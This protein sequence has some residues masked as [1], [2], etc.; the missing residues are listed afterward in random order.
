M[1]I[2]LNSF[3][4]F[5]FLLQFSRD[6]GKVVDEFRLRVVYIPA[7]PPSPVPEGDEEGTTSPGTSSAEDEIRK[8]SFS[9]A[10]SVITNHF[11]S[12]FLPQLRLSL[13]SVLQ[14]FR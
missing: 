12:L 2:I 7:N 9:E 14:N 8:S 13:I 3:F 5:F 6:E 10:V 4:F 1:F 11:L